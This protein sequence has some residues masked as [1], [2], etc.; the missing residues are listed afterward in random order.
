[1]TKF[2][3]LYEATACRCEEYAVDTHRTFISRL[4]SKEGRKEFYDRYYR[5]LKAE[6]YDLGS[7]E[8]FEANFD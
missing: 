4:Q 8:S 5:K 3:K 1:M 6:N 2:E 7:Y